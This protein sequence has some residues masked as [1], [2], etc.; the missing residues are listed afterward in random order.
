MQDLTQHIKKGTYGTGMSKKTGNAY[1]YCDVIF[2]N[3]YKLRVFLTDEQKF[4]I[5]SL[6]AKSTPI[7]VITEDDEDLSGFLD[8]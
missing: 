2:K 4:I 6:F 8:N 7:N 5:K 3:D 1:T